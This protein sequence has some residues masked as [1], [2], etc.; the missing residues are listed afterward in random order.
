VS[1]EARPAPRTTWLAGKRSAL[2]YGADYNPDQWPPEVWAE[3][4]R[5]MREAGINLVSVGIFSWA[6]LEPASGVYDLDWLVRVLDLLHVRGVS[7][8]LATPTAA[9]PAWLVERHPEILPVDEMGATLR[10]GSRRHYCPHAPAYREAARR[11][12]RVL[13]ERFC[14]HPALAMWHVDNEYGCHVGECFCERSRA[15]F[16]TWLA[17]RHGSIEALNAAW[18]TATWGQTYTAWSQ[19]EPP[20]HLPTFGNPGH[21]LD[22]RRFC[23][24]S[25]IDCFL[26]QKAIL[27]ELTPEIPVTTNFMGFHP[28]IDYWALAAVEDLVAQDAYPETSDP[29]WRIEAAMTCDLV[30]SLGRGRPWLLMEQA[31][32]YATWREQNSTKRPG[33][34]RVGS[35]QSIARGAD[36]VMFFQWRTAPAGAEMHTIGLISPTGTDNRQWREAVALGAELPRLAE[37]RGSEVRAKVAIVFDWVNRWALETEGKLDGDVKLMPLVSALYRAFFEMGL[38]VDFVQAGADLSRYSL[39]VAPHLYLVGD[40]DAANLRRYVEAGGTLLMS[41]FSGLVDESVRIRPGACPPPFAGLLGLHVEEFAPFAGPMSNAIRTAQG[42][43]FDCR[44]WGEVVRTDGAETLAT[45]DSDFYAGLPAVTRNAVGRGTAMYMA[46]FPDDEG[47]RWVVETA[48]R[49]ADIAAGGDARPG[50]EI[51]ERT[52]GKRS[53]LFVLNYADRPVEVILDRPGVELISGRPAVGSLTIGPVD[54]A[55]VALG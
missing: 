3:D 52:D 16:R 28:G 35:Y 27:R 2:V 36:G 14:S 10:P 8:D 43:S 30:R 13:A 17:E 53:W 41:F 24:D 47:V 12:A 31:V 18:G 33:V 9:P 51:V 21:E 6:K 20:R 37:I 49:E 44:V 38:T 48:C 26:D 1:I 54:V 45:F 40:A 15:A 5:L 46:T 29:D 23:S 55:V 11:I 25:W 19:I 39:V 22:W 34:M 42:R 4:A 32:A 50:V 7:V